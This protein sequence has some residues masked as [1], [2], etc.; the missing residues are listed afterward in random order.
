MEMK[1]KLPLCEKP[2]MIANQ[3]YALPL[4]IIFTQPQRYEDWFYNEFTQLQALIAEPSNEMQIK[5]YS[6]LNDGLFA[7]LDSIQIPYTAF[8][9]GEDIVAFYRMLLKNGY[10]VRSFCN[11]KFFSSL[12]IENDYFHDFLIFGFDDDTSTF[13]VRAYQDYHLKDVK[14]SYDEMIQGH[15]TADRSQSVNQFIT[16]YRLN[17]FQMESIVDCFSWRLMDYLGGIN[18]CRR[19]QMI[20]YGFD[21]CY[22]GIRIYDLFDRFFENSDSN[23]VYIG[24]NSWYTVYEHKQHM[25]NKCRHFLKKGLIQ[26]SDS[27][28]QDLGEICNTAMR[29]VALHVKTKLKQGHN[30]EKDLQALQRNVKLLKEQELETY[31]SLCRLNGWYVERG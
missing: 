1:T 7:P 13:D 28:D 19:E 25:Q 11:V 30:I 17:D 22:W 31:A 14:V 8:D 23:P 29:C 27:L 24:R 26:Y 10:Y 20:N 2:P 21:P 18:T 12:H 15:L 9:V 16:T 4:S 3:F 5:L 6:A